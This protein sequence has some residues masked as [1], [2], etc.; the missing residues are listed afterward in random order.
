MFLG[1][2]YTWQS[3]VTAFIQEVFQREHTQKKNMLKSQEY[4]KKFRQI[5]G[6]VIWAKKS[7]LATMCIVQLDSTIT[8]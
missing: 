8:Q 1:G 6:R 5:Q 7:F 4:V 3:F 2:K